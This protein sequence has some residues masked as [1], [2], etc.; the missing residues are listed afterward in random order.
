MSKEKPFKQTFGMSEEEYDKLYPQKEP[1]KKKLKKEEDL[2]RLAVLLAKLESTHELDGFEKSEVR[3][4]VKR[5]GAKLKDSHNDYLGIKH[6]HIKNLILATVCIVI[7]VGIGYQSY[8]E[9]NRQKKIADTSAAEAARLAADPISS[10]GIYTAINTLRSKSGA[11]ALA[12]LKELST[13]A[14]QGCE[15]MAS[16]GY[17]DYKNPSSG[18]DQNSRIVDNKGDLYLKSYVSSIAYGDSSLQT[19]TDVA[20]KILESQAT[21]INNSVYNSVGWAVCIPTKKA[22]QQTSGTAVYIV[23]MLAEKAEKPVVPVNNYVAPKY[24]PPAISLPKTEYTNCYQD[25]AGHLQ[26]TTTKY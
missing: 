10:N 12:N 26:C 18:K 20:K 22:P 7:L 1:S 14:Q 17:F 23:G 21:N 9:S 5:T 6:R 19:S 16:G 4:I 15:D 25:L 2:S 24:T 8:V 11:Q 13:A 3:G